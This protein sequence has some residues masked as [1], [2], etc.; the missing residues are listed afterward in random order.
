[1]TVEEKVYAILSAAPVIIPANR[2]K[3]PGNW[4]N[5][6]RP[7]IQH[8]PVSIHPTYTHE[9]LE[10]LKDWEFYQ[11]DVFS[12]DYASGNAVAVAV[13]DRLGNYR[14]DGLVIFLEPGPWY[15]G[16]DPDVNYEHFAPHFRIAETL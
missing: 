10:N 8:F 6:A 3:P 9:R 5:L 4:Q 1:M 16:R 14:Q 12:D 2:I 15:V 11:V 13:R 7:Y